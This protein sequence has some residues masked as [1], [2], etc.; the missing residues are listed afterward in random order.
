MVSESKAHLCTETRFSMILS[1][2]LPP[3]IAFTSSSVGAAR[4]SKDNLVSLA[5]EIKSKQAGRDI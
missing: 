5:A 3:F 4:F 2:F 1:V